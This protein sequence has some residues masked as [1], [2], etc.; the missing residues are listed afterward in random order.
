MDRCIYKLSPRC[1]QD[2]LFVMIRRD[3]GELFLHCEECEWAWKAPED[4]D[5]IEK[6]FLG[7]NIDADYARAK[8]VEQAGWSKYGVQCGKC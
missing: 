4:A 7:L 6:G 3:I 1:K 2:V 5:S 8:E